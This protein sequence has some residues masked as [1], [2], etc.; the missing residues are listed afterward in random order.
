[1]PSRLEKTLNT[2]LITSLDELCQR[3]EL[4]SELSSSLTEA[5]RSFPFLVPESV[6]N[7]IEKGNPND[8]ILKQF[9]PSLE[10]L[11][12]KAGFVLDPLCEFSGNESKPGAPKESQFL[13]QK[14]AGRVLVLTS[15]ACAARC[16]FC[17]RRHFHGPS[18]FPIP[19]EFYQERSDADD[20]EL[21]TTSSK[22]NTSFDR[23]F[24]SVRNNPSISEIIFS[25]GDP[26]TLPDD[27]LKSLLHS[28]KTL[29]SVKRVRFH[30]RIPVLAPQRIG[31]NFPSNDDVN[32]VD[33]ES[34]LVLH[35]AVHVN[36]PNEIDASVAR[37]L[38]DLRKRGYVLTSQ[39]TLLKGVNDSSDTLVELFEKL[40]NCGVIPYYLHQF[41][42]VQ[43]A[44]HFETPVKRGLELMKEIAERLPGY[45][46]PKY[47]REIPGRASKVNL[48]AEPN[49]DL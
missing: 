4:P 6:L 33:D 3:L 41:D 18:L 12:E 39:T 42:R 31:A 5:T 24:H 37:A 23:V 40:A 30:S 28:I 9:L 17:F 20:T 46:V 43:G 34:P 29:R 49:A 13:L 48:L 8:P 35:L 25:G 32:S 7:R 47:V 14:Y 21:S 2:R 16:R 38:F 1:M 44:A 11:E 36:S 26:L 15:N 22:I 10:E 27:Q 45:A 19:A